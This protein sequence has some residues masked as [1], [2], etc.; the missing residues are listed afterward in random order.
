MIKKAPHLPNKSCRVDTYYRLENIKWLLLFTLLAFIAGVSASAIFS[1]WFMSTFEPI[2]FVKYG[3]NQDKDLFRSTPDSLLQRQVEQRLMTIYDT[4]KKTGDNFYS[5][6]AF[7]GK[8]SIISSDG[9]LVFYNSNYILGQEKFWEV[10]DYQ[11]IKYKVDKVVY[12][13]SNR[14][15]YVKIAAQ[16]LRVNSFPS[17]HEVAEGQG[18]WLINFSTW[19]NNYFGGWEGLVGTV[20]SFA[21]DQ[22]QFGLKIIDNTLSGSVA[23]DNQGNL[24]GF[25]DERNLLIPGWPIE[26]QI[27]SLLEKSKL[28]D[29]GIGWQGEFIFGDFDFG[30]LPNDLGFYINFSDTLPTANTI[31]K[32]DIILKVNGQTIDQFKFAEQLWLAPDQ[33]SVSLWR[34]GGVVDVLITK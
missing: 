15:L 24:L 14:L 19:E 31:G 33:F 11:Y 23:I 2:Q 21:V 26:K 1:S 27:S 16:G 18:L 12:D 32:G 20:G 4:K 13:K 30:N 6:R 10:L 7:I 28:T 17:W 34:D 29:L 9:W 22:R 25:A 8:A 3:V 5:Q